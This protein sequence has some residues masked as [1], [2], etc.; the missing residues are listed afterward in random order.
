MAFPKD[1]CYTVYLTDG[2][3]S[4]ADTLNENDNVFSDSL[5]GNMLDS[6]TGNTTDGYTLLKTIVVEP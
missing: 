3:N 4:E 1:T 5:D 2:Y 6:I